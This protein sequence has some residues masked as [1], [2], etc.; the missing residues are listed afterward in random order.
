MGVR[1][2]G[3][4]K[5]QDGRGGLGEWRWF[6][7]IR[8]AEDQ[9]PGD[10][11]EAGGRSKAKSKGA[12]FCQVTESQ[13]HR[14]PVINSLSVTGRCAGTNNSIQ[15]E[16]GILA[17]RRARRARSRIARQ[18]C[19]WWWWWSK[20]IWEKQAA[21]QSKLAKQCQRSCRRTCSSV[22][23]RTSPGPG[24]SDRP[25]LFGLNSPIF[26]PSVLPPPCA[27]IRPL[28]NVWEEAGWGP[29]GVREREIVTLAT[30]RVTS[31]PDALPSSPCPA[32]AE[33]GTEGQGVTA[34]VRYKSLPLRPPPTAL[35]ASTKLRGGRI[36]CMDVLYSDVLS[37]VVVGRH[38][39]AASSFGLFLLS[40]CGT[41]E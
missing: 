29:E 28:R 5:R 24:P 2:D 32:Q 13:S 17:A 37:K 35:L 39:R 27:S 31:G 23:T 16:R 33:G 25:Q 21:K 4:A 30:A 14:L 19:R 38:G 10:E 7:I 36:Q 1:N 6:C 20:A 40:W 15:L 22:K 8:T 41:H 9:R 3:G 34:R 18:G 26:P 12:R 11:E